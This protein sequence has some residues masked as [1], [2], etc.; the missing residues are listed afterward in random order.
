LADSAAGVLG[1]TTELEDVSAA[2]VFD[3][4]QFA[5]VLS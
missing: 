4:T 1:Q 5:G 2:T 3:I